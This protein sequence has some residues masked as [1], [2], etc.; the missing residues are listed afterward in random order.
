[1][2]ISA[3]HIQFTNKCCSDSFDERIAV[4]SELHKNMTSSGITLFALWK[5]DI[6]FNGIKKMLTIYTL[7]NTIYMKIYICSQ[8]HHSHTYDT[9][10]SI[11][12]EPYNQKSVNKYTTQDRVRSADKIKL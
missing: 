9:L 3:L 1:M 11:M 12:H 5:K 10:T 6:V 8:M 4:S 2:N 7:Y